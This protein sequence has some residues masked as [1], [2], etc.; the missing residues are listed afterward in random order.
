MRG[1]AALPRLEIGQRSG[2]NKQLVSKA[3]IIGAYSMVLSKPSSANT[4]S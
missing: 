1:C 3:A 2:L 4:P